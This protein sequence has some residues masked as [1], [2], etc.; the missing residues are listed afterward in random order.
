MYRPRLHCS[1][2]SIIY[3]D[4]FLTDFIRR[5]LD[6]FLETLPHGIAS[7]LALTLFEFI[8]K[9]LISYRYSSCSCASSSCCCCGETQ[10]VKSSSLRRSTETALYRQTMN[11]WLVSGTLPWEIKKLIYFQCATTLSVVKWP[12]LF[13]SVSRCSKTTDKQQ[14]TNVVNSAL[15]N[16]KLRHIAT[17]VI[18]TAEDCAAV[19]I[20]VVAIWRN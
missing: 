18:T 1:D 17:T 15:T 2:A 12:F 20:T 11:I 5:L 13:V 8:D 14:A 9:E 4:F 7:T 19:V 10:V 16:L 3:L 6:D